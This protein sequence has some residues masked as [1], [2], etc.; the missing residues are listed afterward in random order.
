MFDDGLD[1]HCNNGRSRLP[2][3]FSDPWRQFGLQVY[4]LTWLSE[5]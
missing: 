2:D 4:I 5:A 1:I 3:D